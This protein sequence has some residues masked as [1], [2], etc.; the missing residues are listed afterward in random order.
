MTTPPRIEEKTITDADLAV[1]LPQNTTPDTFTT[2]WGTI[3]AVGPL[4]V[5]VDG[6]AE[7]EDSAV[8][9]TLDDTVTIGERVL[10]L[11]SGSQLIILG[12]VSDDDVDTY[13]SRAAAS[14]ATPFEIPA[15]SDLNSYIYPGFF[16]QSANAD[17]AAGTNYPEPYAGHLEVFTNHLRLPLLYEEVGRNYALDP[18]ATSWIPNGGLG[19]GNARWHGSSGGSGTYA[20]VTGAT[21]G[22]ILSDGT[23]KLS[24]YARKT[25]T[26]V[27]AGVTDLGFE[28]TKS[29]LTGYP[30]V[31][32]DPYAISSFVRLSVG[33]GDGTASGAH[34]G[35]RFYT[36][37]GAQLGSDVVSDWTIL[38]AGVWTRLAVQ[39]VVPAG[40]AF[41]Q[42]TSDIEG[43]AAT[44]G[45]VLDGTGLLV[46]K[47]AVLEDYYDGSY[48]LSSEVPASWTGTVNNSESVLQVVA[49]E[50][51]GMIWQRYWLY[52]AQNRTYTRTC[53]NGTWYP[54]VGD[55]TVS[56]TGVITSGTYY[57][58]KAD[59]ELICRGTGVYS[60][61]ANTVLTYSWTFP[62]AFIY[63]PQVVIISETTVPQ[64]I[65]WS[66]SN[67]SATAVD[68]KF[69][70]TTSSN[71]TF[72][73]EAKGRWK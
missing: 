59:G 40:A 11:L 66:T 20:L 28:H 7:D 4:R 19:W 31:P 38:E 55:G 61:T 46:E 14:P 30:V 50:Q 27:G 3:T 67:L 39:F 57:W 45:M 42:V 44:N 51:P 26:A 24:T 34:L 37:A 17:A 47:D 21:D 68:L 15:V 43:V 32:L 60:L 56:L 5:K 13:L 18:R 48:A 64:L 72:W 2:Q 1:L 12:R 10:C 63:E 65:T 9:S 33:Y 6:P 41:M 53:Y 69:H 25:W 58:K 54:W 29:G 49:V 70:R 73:Y 8:H 22:P 35:V 23:T 16:T 52:G 71:T 36:A 62:H